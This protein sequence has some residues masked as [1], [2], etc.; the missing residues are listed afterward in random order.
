MRQAQSIVLAGINQVGGRQRGE[1]KR[2]DRAV[3]FA[4][5]VMLTSPLA[6]VTVPL[7]LSVTSPTVAAFRQIGQQKRHRDEATSG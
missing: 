5:N 1:I 4:E 2:R 3:G 7:P 6:I